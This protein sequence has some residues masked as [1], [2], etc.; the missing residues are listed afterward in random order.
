MLDKRILSIAKLADELQNIIKGCIDGNRIAQEQLYNRFASKMYGVCL[1]Y[2]P[3]AEEAQDALQEGFIKIF[4]KI[5]QFKNTG[6]LEGWIRKIMVNT[7]LESYRKQKHL[8]ITNQIPDVQEEISDNWEANFSE[9]DLMILIQDLP[10]RYRMVFNL[11]VF[12]EMTHKE[13]AKELGITEGTSK[14]DLSRAR[15]ILQKKINILT[16]KAIK[17]G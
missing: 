8:Q 17:I 13:I 10:E 15:G 12:E 7:S 14:S 2:S 5:Y 11:Y 9:R 16:K 6:P 4:E 3:N 1:R